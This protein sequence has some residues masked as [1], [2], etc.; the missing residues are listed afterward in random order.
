MTT[1]SNVKKLNKKD[2]MSIFWRSCHQD[3][4]WNYERQQNLAAGYTMCKVIGK[5][6]ADDEEGRS[7]ALQRHLEFMAITPHLSTL[8]YGILA[9]ME[10]EN[11]NNESFDENSINAVRASLMGPLAGIGDSLIWG[12]LRIIAAGI[13]IS[14]SKDGNIMGPLIFLLIFNIPAWLLRYFCLNKG[15]SLGADVFKQVTESGLMEKVTYAASVVGLMVIGCMSASMVY[16]ELPIKVGSGDFAQPL[17]DYL[18]EVMP[19]LL[20]LAIFGVLYYFLG[21]KVKTTTILLIIIVLSI[22]L[23]FFG[24]V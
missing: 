6:Y 24:I 12:T 14:F 4:S 9:A 7:R 19:C 13:A 2:L 20:P 10:E 15:Y 22:V 1:N 17:Q 23:A 16:F 8:L 3:A 21:K 11:A 5:L 18:N